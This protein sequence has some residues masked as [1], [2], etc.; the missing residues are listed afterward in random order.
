MQYNGKNIKTIKDIS[1]ANKIILVRTDYNIPLDG[2]TITDDLRIKA[3]LP[4]I[5]YLLTNGAAKIILISHLGRPDGQPDP[6][7]SLAPVAD[8]LRQ[9]LPNTP[10]EFVPAI[11]GDT[12]SAAVD[13]LPTG[14]ILLLENLR[15]SPDEEANSKDFAKAIATSTHAELFVQ[16]GFAVVHRAHAS[17]DSITHIL[18]SV[19]GLLLEEEITKL[20]Q[21]SQ[22]PTHPFLVI[23][24]GAKVDDKQLM[25]DKFLPIADHVVVGGKIAADGFVNSDPKVF[26]ADDF[27]TDASGAKLDIGQQ[28]TEK[29]ITLI[30]QAQTILWN[31][32]LGKAEDPTY[33][34][35][36]TAIA[37]QTGQSSATSIIGGGDTAGFVENLQKTHPTLRYTLIS[38][39]GGASLDLLSGKLLPGVAAL[40]DKSP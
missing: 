13:A 15:F 29:I 12:V 1:V 6:A 21:I 18:P 7:L 35:S 30:N 23:I 2:Q 27:L 14:G 11:T 19:A 25:I 34:Q 31:G 36:S 10:I 26:V 5:Q 40:I 16:D 33:A 20:A 39:G 22:N 28:S 37:L 3:S 24:G 17:T 32:L 4:T 9:L 38:T 8:R